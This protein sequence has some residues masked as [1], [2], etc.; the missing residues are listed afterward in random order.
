MFSDKLLS[1]VS[2]QSA[3]L[4]TFFQFKRKYIEA[5]LQKHLLCQAKLEIL[6]CVSLLFFSLLLVFLYQI[7]T[8]KYCSEAYEVAH[9][10]MKY[11]HIL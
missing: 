2:K 4:A 6:G 3:F 1:P 11:T 10:F 9:G 8:Q 5:L 7:F